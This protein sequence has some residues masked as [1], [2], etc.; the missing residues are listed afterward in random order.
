M[1]AE[2]GFE[3]LIAHVLFLQARSSHFSAMGE[4]AGVRKLWF[5]SLVLF[6]HPDLFTL[7]LL[8]SG[9]SRVQIKAVRIVRGRLER[10]LSS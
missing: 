2:V 9:F 5:M 8:K 4:S 7:A 10:W 6:S 3:E 1:A